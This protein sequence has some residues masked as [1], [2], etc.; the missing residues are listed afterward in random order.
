[1]LARTPLHALAASSDTDAA[2]LAAEALLLARA[3][4][5]AA[6][7]DGK[8]AAQL[9]ADCGH[10]RLLAILLRATLADGADAPTDAPEPAAWWLVGCCARG[11]GG[12]SVARSP[13][14]CAL[15]SALLDEDTDASLGIGP[16][17]CARAA[18]LLRRAVRAHPLLERPRARAD[19]AASEPAAGSDAPTPS[20][21]REQSDSP[22]LP[23]ARPSTLASVAKTIEAGNCTGTTDSRAR[24][25]RRASDASARLSIEAVCASPRPWRSPSPPAL[26]TPAVC[27]SGA[28]RAGALACTPPSS[29]PPTPTPLVLQPQHS[30]A[31]GVFRVRRRGG[32]AR[33][34]P[35]A[36]PGTDE[37]RDEEEA[38]V[39]TA[40]R[41]RTRLRGGWTV[42]HPPLLT[43]LFDSFALSPACTSAS[44]TPT[45][46]PSPVRRRGRL[47]TSS[48]PPLGWSTAG[49]ADAVRRRLARNRRI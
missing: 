15:T 34:T 5:T 10:T 31:S 26:K 43:A 16:P 32:S 21:R 47:R 1:M 7:S 28:Q 42:M 35:H 11:P 23:T 3:D 38:T 19:V 30:A 33:E 44:P 22:P 49:D 13:A 14:R 6:D 18:T 17:L 2:S 45:R 25:S 36:A 24:H 27:G 20:P 9:A 46:T 48:P 29:A 8:T 37:R 12:S 40:P 39:A 41:G 4:A